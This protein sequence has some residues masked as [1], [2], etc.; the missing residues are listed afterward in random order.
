MYAFLC[1]RVFIWIIFKTICQG[2]EPEGG[3]GGGAEIKKYCSVYQNIT[4][5]NTENI[6]RLSALIYST[7]FSS[8]VQPVTYINLDLKN[9]PENTEK[10]LPPNKG[11]TPIGDVFTSC[12]WLFR[13]GYVS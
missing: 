11:C 3:M 6:Q 4:Q 13:D 10:A 9:H 7:C 12:N 2:E 5:I 1:L 8:L